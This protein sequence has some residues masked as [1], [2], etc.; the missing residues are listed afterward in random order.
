MGE[1][2]IIHWYT[3]GLQV[4]WKPMMPFCDVS[5]CCVQGSPFNQTHS[6]PFTTENPKSNFSTWSY[7][8]RLYRIFLSKDTQ[9]LSSFRHLHV[10]ILGRFMSSTE[11]QFQRSCFEQRFDVTW[12]TADESGSSEN[13]RWDWKQQQQ[14][15]VVENLLNAVSFWRIERK[16]KNL[17]PV[18]CVFYTLSMALLESSHTFVA[19]DGQH[20]PLELRSITSTWSS[21]CLSQWLPGEPQH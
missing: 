7:F 11:K 5:M 15:N 21:S 9:F 8:W 3:G 2:C 20:K 16:Q 10:I 6:G 12:S 13:H 18:I 4:S 14:K 17:A 1:S 19:W